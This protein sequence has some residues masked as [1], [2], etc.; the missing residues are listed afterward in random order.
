MNKKILFG[1]LIFLLTINFISAELVEVETD[2]TMK[3]D[4]DTITVETEEKDFTFVCGPGAPSPG[5]KTI[6]FTRDLECAHT[7]ELRTIA[8]TLSANMNKSLKYYDKYL[9]CYAENQMCQDKLSGNETSKNYVEKYTEKADELA[10]CESSK[11]N[12]VTSRQQAESQLSTCE[13]DL[14]GCKESRILIGAACIIIGAVGYHFIAGKTGKPAVSV[15]EQQ[16]PK[17]R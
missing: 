5:T 14:E 7:D 8:S 2:I 6:A 12:L 10:S 15:A 4:N 9:D 17:S 11:T 3:V 16:L 1:I 13:E